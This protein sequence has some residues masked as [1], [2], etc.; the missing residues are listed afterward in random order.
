MPRG[1]AS[2]AKGPASNAIRKASNTE[3]EGSGALFPSK[4][5]RPVIVL[6]SL[7]GE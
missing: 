4:V 1:K 2:S 3:K 5:G 6:T 7:L